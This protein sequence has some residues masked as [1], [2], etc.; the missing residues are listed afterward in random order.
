MPRSVSLSLKGRSQSDIN[1]RVNPSRSWNPPSR[2]AP[3]L[4]LTCS[5]DEAEAQAAAGK[6][7]LGFDRDET[8]RDRWLVKSFAQRPPEAQAA[9]LSR[10]ADEL[11]AEVEAG[12]PVAVVALWHPKS[13]TNARAI[14][15]ALGPRLRFDTHLPV[16]RRLQICRSFER[17]GAEGSDGLFVHCLGCTTC[18]GRG[19]PVDL[20]ESEC[21]RGLWDR[22]SKE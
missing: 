1:G 22:D 3:D 18:N 19:R 7:H 8:G 5:R 2:T 9:R 12:M 11:Q 4:W 6:V 21:P 15:E 14:R 16:T 10:W 20:L 17:A 13:L